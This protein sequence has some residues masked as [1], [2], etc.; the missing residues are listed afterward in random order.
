M[1][2]PGTELNNKINFAI[3]TASIGP[4]APGLGFGA[5]ANAAVAKIPEV[6]NKIKPIE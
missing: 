6:I 5:G 3:K 1:I 4:M 2:P